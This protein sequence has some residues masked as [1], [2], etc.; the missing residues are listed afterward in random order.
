VRAILGRPGW[1][2]TDHLLADLWRVT[3]QAHSED[4]QK[5][6]DHP[7]RAEM[8]A[9]AA[10]REKSERLSGLKSRFKNLKHLYGNTSGG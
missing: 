3:V 9:A 1:S 4:P 6:G 7:V 8:I 2:T 5:V 10:I